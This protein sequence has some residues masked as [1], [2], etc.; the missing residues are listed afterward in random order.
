M[1][2]LNLFIKTLMLEAWFQPEQLFDEEVENATE[3]LFD[4]LDTEM[5]T[6]LNEADRDIYVELRNNNES[7]DPAFEFAKMKISNFDKFIREKMAEFRLEYLEWM[8]AK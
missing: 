1:D 4:R 5:M 6:K 7:L 3:I 8:S 2:E